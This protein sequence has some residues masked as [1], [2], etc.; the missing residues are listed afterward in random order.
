M[1]EAEL[2]EQEAPL[3]WPLQSHVAA[4]LHQLGGLVA[5]REDE[6]PTQDTGVT[7]ENRVFALRAFCRC[8]GHVHPSGSCPPNFS[9]GDFSV[10]WEVDV[11]A[12]ARQS[13]LLTRH[14]WA[15]MLTK[16]MASLDDPGAVR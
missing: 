7:F 12:G 14:E 10:F 11:D 6:D 1:A 15:A 4:G 3:L 16:C 13:R 9:C 8:R 5:R 2:L